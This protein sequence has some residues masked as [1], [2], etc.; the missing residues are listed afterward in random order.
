MIQPSLILFNLLI[1][2]TFFI[3]RHYF[4][5]YW[6][7][8]YDIPKIWNAKV[9]KPRIAN[10]SLLYPLTCIS[11]WVLISNEDVG[12]FGLFLKIVLIVFFGLFYTT[13][14]VIILTPL[15]NFSKRVKNFTNEIFQDKYESFIFSQP[16]KEIEFY[17]RF[18]NEY[19]STNPEDFSS[20]LNLLPLNSNQ[21]ITWLYSKGNRKSKKDNNLKALY[22][23]VGEVFLTEDKTFIERTIISYFKNIDDS[24]YTKEA[25]SNTFNK[26][27]ANNPKHLQ[28]MTSELKSLSDK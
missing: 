5:F 18:N 17:K 26:W 14:L 4:I 21:K 1:V 6:C 25:L 15:I 11:A 10:L 12:Y 3:F 9:E 27:Q 13:S 24:S 28:N 19:F 20:F 7:Y 22:H 23:F 8:M 2:L 16:E